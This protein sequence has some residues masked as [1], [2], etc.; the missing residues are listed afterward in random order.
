MAH[1]IL[2][3]GTGLIGGAVLLHILN[4]PPDNAISKVTI[5][6]RSPVPLATKPD[7]RNTTTQIEVIIHTDYTSYPPELLSRVQGVKAVIWAQGISQTRVSRT[8]YVEITK[9]YPLAAFRAFS[10]LPLP[11][12][13]KTPASK[14]DFIHITAHGTT[15]NP[16]FYTPYYGRIKGEAELALFKISQ[17]EPYAS[18][19]NLYN[20]R[21]G[22]VIGTMQPEIWEP[23]LQ[24]HRNNTTYAFAYKLL[25]PIYQAV[26]ENAL[27]PTPELGKFLTDLA[28]MVPGRDK[29]EDEALL[30]DNYGR[31]IENTAI[32]RICG[33]KIH[34]GQ[35]APESCI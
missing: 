13:D 11:T 9:D 27:I 35:I 28:V 2:T 22:G 15:Y 34:R 10:S 23:F 17:Q 3:G 32:R 16:K 30:F 24:R 31:V 14:L 20:V 33:L 8:K 12:N 18:T 21:A 6:S 1:I 7:R 4:L 25:V 29:V 26:R 19:I 5:L